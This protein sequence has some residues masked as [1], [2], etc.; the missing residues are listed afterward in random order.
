[1]PSPLKIGLIGSRGQLGQELVRRFSEPDLSRKVSLLCLDRP[2]FDITSPSSLGEIPGAGFD[3]ILNTSAYNA[4]DRGETEVR[5][6]F[7]LNAFAPLLLAR[8]CREAGTALLHVSTDYVMSGGIHEEEQIPYPE[9][10]PTRPLSVYGLSK[11][12]GERLVTGAWERSWIVRTC[13]LYGGSGSGQ[14]GGN[15]VT[16]MVRLARE[17]KPLRVVSDQRV[18]PTAA[19]DLA[20]GIARLVTAPLPFGLWHLTNAGNVSWYEF[21]RRIFELSGLAPD[22]SPVPLALYRPVAPRSPFSVLS[23]EK[24]HRTG[25]VLPSWEIALADYLERSGL[26]AGS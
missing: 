21:A 8:A 23:N 18:G 11:A 17:G 6:C 12:T 10:A 1:V 22:L 14:K 7:E 25:I 4:V 15:F 16:T 19:R 5:E 13:G 20:R 3:I 24:A 2:A 9:E 26:L